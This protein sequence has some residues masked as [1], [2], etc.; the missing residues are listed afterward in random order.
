VPPIKRFSYGVLALCIFWLVGRGLGYRH[1]WQDEVETA[2]RARTI[3]ESGYPRVID[4]SGALSVNTGGRELED[5]VAHRYTPW[6]QFYAG[7]AGLQAAR[8]LGLSDDAGVRLPFVTAHAIEGAVLAFGLHRLGGLPLPFSLA[9]AAAFSLH[10][11]RVVYNR[12]ARYHALLDLFALLGLCG[13]GALRKGRRAGGWLVAASCFLA[14]QTHTLGGAYVAIVL[15]YL[16]LVLSDPP[17][18][19]TPLGARLRRVLL[20]CVV[21]GAATLALLIALVRP[22]RQT[23]WGGIRLAHAKGQSLIDVPGVDYALAFVAVYA[24]ACLLCRD[25]GRALRYALLLPLCAATLLALDCV[26]LSQARYYLSTPLLLCG[27]LLAIG[28]PDKV[29][30]RLRRAV[31]ASVCAIPLLCEV[32]LGR[33]AR[34]DVRTLPFPPLQGVRLALSDVDRQRDG[35]VQPLREVLST[36]RQLGRPG[37]AVLI[38]YVPQFVNWYLPGFTPALVPDPTLKT[39]LNQDQPLWRTPPPMPEWHLWYANWQGGFWTCLNQCDFSATGY[40]ADRSEY[41]L[42][43][44]WRG[45]EVRMCVVKRLGASPHNNAPFMMFL[46]QS[47]GTR[48]PQAKTLVLARRC[49]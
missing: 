19:T 8:W 38:D 46:D 4:R 28:L 13:L 45:E 40:R 33:Y 23:A 27:S 6:L 7:A 3:L 5:G 15:T 1:L 30:P 42:R 11:V 35:M 34:F 49:R 41:T 2:E 22:L 29:P 31:W 9:A 47:F 14:P 43:S 24:A 37:D 44:R 25:R 39:P 36:I 12:S 21:P 18:G 26:P 10:T 20:L 17:D 16:T 48:G 32:L